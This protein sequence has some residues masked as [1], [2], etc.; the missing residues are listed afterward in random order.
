MGAKNSGVTKVL[1]VLILL[2]GAFLRIYHLFK[3]DFVHEPFRL[4]GLFVAFSQQIAQNG[5]RLPVTI[6]FYSEGGIPYAYPPVG[7]YVEAALLKLF[8][9][10]QLI[11]ANFLPPCLA[12]LT[13]LCAS[14]LLRAIFRD[15][16]LHFLAGLFACAFIVNAF[17]NQ[18]EAAGLAEATGSVALL[19]YFAGVYR[20]RNAPNKLNALLAG[21][22]LGLCVLASPGSAVGAAL[23]SVLLF[24]EAIIKR[25]A[26]ASVWLEGGIMA[27]SGALISAPYW[28]T[29]MLNHGR[30][31]FILP[32]LAQY[33]MAGGKTPFLWSLLGDLLNFNLSYGGTWTFLWQ[34]VIFLG[35]LW[36]LLK[37]KPAIPL[38][39]LALFSIPREDVWLIAFP[40]ALLFAYGFADVLVP[41]A[42]PVLEA[43][44]ALKK[45]AV[46]AVFAVLALV[47]VF[48]PFAYVDAVIADQQ[49]K[50]TPVQ[51]DGV[52][53]AATY[54]PPQAKVLVLGNDALL[55]WSPYLLQREV[56]NTKFGLEWQPDK[57]AKINDLNTKLQ[58]A[59]T[60]DDVLADVQQMDGQTQI[61]VLST[62]K[63]LLSALNKASTVSIQ[64]K[65]ETPDVQVG[66]LSAP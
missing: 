24:V 22:A 52:K 13:L 9:G 60:W 48:Q 66:V 10:G 3:V 54:I 2:G 41:L 16:D 11:L 32:V 15:R 27:V 5:F 44:P 21:A 64:M 58:A 6:P 20:Y 65:L 39:F 53:N 42:R 45:Y 33:Q 55:E 35:L 18:I 38:A 29:V 25:M 40:A 23:L 49:W 31:I 50:L 51:Y 14:L 19:A 28:V 7:F 57:L 56:I 43:G 1:T 12:I 26:Q 4:G 8:P 34:V 63:S 62:Q 47:L 30:G 36:L 61:Y 37:G 17:T 46:I 59:R